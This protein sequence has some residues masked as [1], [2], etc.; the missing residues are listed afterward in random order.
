M[1]HPDRFQLTDQERSS[2][3]WGR[4]RAFYETRLRLLR[5]QNDGPM[6]FE[7]TEKLR[8]R[9]HEVKSI[10]SLNDTISTPT[11]SE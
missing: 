6:G 9:I 11:R 3:L 4:L 5:A 2:A 10:L 1:K 8:G 7:A